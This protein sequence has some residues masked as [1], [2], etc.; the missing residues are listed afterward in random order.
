MGEF[1]N[2][3]YV[4][5]FKSFQTAHAVFEAHKRNKGGTEGEEDESEKNTER[6]GFHRRGL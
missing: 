2:D 6:I 4:L 3:V 1:K 5:S